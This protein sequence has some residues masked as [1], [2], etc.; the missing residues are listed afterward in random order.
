MK[1]EVRLSYK[2]KAQETENG[3]CQ[4]L[5]VE[6]KVKP[7]FAFIVYMNIFHEHLHIG[8]DFFAG[9]KLDTCE[10]TVSYMDFFHETENAS[11]SNY[12]LRKKNMVKITFSIYLSIF[13]KQFHI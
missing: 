7:S 9:K 8:K 10:V 11:V 6:K 5:S 13:Y 1:M 12:E 3:S 2:K 4:F